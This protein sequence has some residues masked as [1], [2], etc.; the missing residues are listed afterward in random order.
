MKNLF[1]KVAM[2]VALLAAGLTAYAQSTVTGTVKDAAGD[3]IVGANVFVQGTNNGTVADVDGSFTLNNVRTGASI[4]ISCIGYSSQVV[5]YNGQPIHVVLE[6][7]STMLEGTVVTALGIK[8][9]TKALGYAM[10]ELKSDELNANLINPVS[11]LQGKVAGVEI[12]Q[13]DGGMF[14]HNKILIRGASTLGKNN[15]PIFVVDGIILD[16]DI[17]SVSADWDAN[18]LDYGNELKSLNPDDFETVSVLKGAAATALYGSRG[19]NGAI[20]ITTK[21]GKGSKGLG[22]SVTQTVGMDRVTAQPDFQN[23]FMEGY[24]SG[25]SNYFNAESRWDNHHGNVWMDG[26]ET[27]TGKDRVYSYL[28]M[29]N[30]ILGEQA[31]LSFGNRFDDYNKLEW[32]D[33]NL[34]DSKAKANNFKDAYDTGFNTNTNVTISGGNDR[35]SIYVSLSEKYATGTLP[36]NSFNRF[37]TLVK[38]SHKLNDYIE[39]E[40]STTLTN[41]TP[42]NAQPNIGEYFVDGTWDRTYDAKYLRDKYKGDHGGLAQSGYGDKWGN[43]PGRS[44]WWS[45][46]ENETLQKETVVRP[47]VKL[48]VQFTP[49]L[50]WVT[51]GSFNYYYT[52]REEKRP[53]SGYANS[54]NG[55][56]Y[57]LSM[58]TKEQTNLNTN[59]IADYK[60]NEDWQI[61]GFL[62]GEYFDSYVQS[63]SVHTNGGLVV[64]NRY[65]ISNSKNTVSG[66]GSI[67][68]TKRMLSLVGQA[69]ASYKDLLFLEVTGRNDWTSS[70]VYADKHGNYSYFYPSFSASWLIHESFKLP[71]FISFWKVRASIAQVGNDT[72][73]YIINTAYTVSNLEHDGTAV[74]YMNIPT[75][76]YDS[77][78]K[79]E[80]KTSWEIG[81][82]FRMFNGRI[83]IDATFYKENTRNQIMQVTLPGASGVNAAYINAGNIENKG[84]EL[85]INTIP[86]ETK[87]FS[88]DVNFTFT[89]NWSKIVELSDLV[90]NYIKLEGDPDYGNFR[91]GSVA[92][93]GG[94]YGILMSDAAP[95]KD[96]NYDDDGNI[97]G[98]SGLPILYNWQQNYGTTLIRRNGKVEEIGNSVPDFLGSINTNIR[99]KRLTLHASFDARFGG[100][101]ASYPSHYGTAYGYLGTAL[102]GADADHGG[103]TYTSRWDGLTYDDGVIPEGLFPNGTKIP[104]PDG[105]TFEVGVDGVGNVSENGMTFQEVYDLGKVDPCH[106]SSWTYYTNSWSNAVVNDNW[107]KK[108]NYIC[109]RDLSLAYQVPE[110]FAHAIKAQGLSLQANIH[111]LGYILNTMPNHENPESVRGTAASEFRVR[112]LQ[113]VTTYYTFTVN[114]RF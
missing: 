55:G 17:Q 24:F 92:K 49:W 14:G 20:I 107:F 33:G 105:S 29:Y 61:G 51:D 93:V 82:D 102:K 19:L 30:E 88:W 73:P 9:S 44:V 112:N 63:V 64:P 95:L 65:F 110:R 108:L 3:G 31:G 97:T 100:Y 81:T 50:K 69:T 58:T 26:T 52:R 46:W 12:N 32:Y 96:Y 39:L 74:S 47:N 79:P 18:N 86:V 10:T 54:G 72:D 99:Y 104:Q 62:R 37:S 11:A 98:G 22:V 85:A 113:G 21:N 56:Y 68:G 59:L 114:V 13:S 78:L 43:I 71:D 60:L 15:Q 27:L 89:K 87:D 41:S 48:T 5:V 57:G 2:T 45:I 84:V 80:R 7:D 91:I 109:F 1:I 101:V 4:E 16:N 67:S 42:R 90:A 66:S 103:V 36:N 111:N 23:V 106:Q 28:K 6:E 77:N 53:D 34:I 35:S 94:T 8:R 76:V 70:L 83:G 25:Y 38:A 40:A 75:T